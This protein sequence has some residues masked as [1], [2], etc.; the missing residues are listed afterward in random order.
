MDIGH[1][2]RALWMVLITTI[3]GPFF[4]MLIGG[5]LAVITAALP[6][7]FPYFDGIAMGPAAVGAFLWSAVP[8]IVASVGLVP[9]VLQSGTYGWLHAAVA[10]VV[11]FAAGMF[12]A[13]FASGGLAPVLAFAAG[14]IMILLRQ[15][16]IAKGILI[17]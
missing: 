9:Y 12:V 8:S 13:P 7:L 4:G 14:L 1:G 3:A 2:Q 10:G 6:G 15:L 16:L 5:L 11:G 17:K